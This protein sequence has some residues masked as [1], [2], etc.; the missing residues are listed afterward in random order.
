MEGNLF[1]F[2][3]ATLA[4]ADLR[5]TPANLAAALPISDRSRAFLTTVGLPAAQVAPGLDFNLVET[6]PTPAQAFAGTGFRFGGAWQHTRMLRVRHGAGM[7]LNPADGSV[8]HLVP[9]RVPETCLV[10]TSVELLGYFL[11]ESNRPFGPEVSW[12]RRDTVRGHFDAMVR[13][14]RDADPEALDPEGG[15]FWPLVIEDAGYYI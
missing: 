3:R 15:N 14:M 11:A 7:Y 10:N 4:A 8:W 2:V 12:S 6:L 1:D 9:D 5:V 13:R